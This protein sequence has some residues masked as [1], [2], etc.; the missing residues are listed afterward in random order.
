MI[1]LIYSFLI[2]GQYTCYITDSVGTTIDLTESVCKI[3]PPRKTCSDY[4][5][6][7]AAQNA[8]EQNLPGTQYLDADGDGRVCEWGTQKIKEK[9]QL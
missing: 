6:S 9:E 1:N 8:F 5:S 4:P 7:E 3:K 2:A